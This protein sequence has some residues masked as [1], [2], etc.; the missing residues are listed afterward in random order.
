M[1]R[2]FIAPDAWNRVRDLCTRGRGPE[3]FPEILSRQTDI[4]SLP[5]YL[6]EL[7]Q[8]EWTLNHVETAENSSSPPVNQI[9]VNP[10]L[11]LLRLSWKNLTYLLKAHDNDSVPPPECGEEYVIVWRHPRTGEAAVSPATNEDLLVLKMVAEEIDAR[12]VAADGRVTIHELNA[13][14][15]RAV[16]RGLLVAPA[17]GIQR[18]TSGFPRAEEIEEDFLSASVFT[19][20]WHITQA[21][22]LHCRHCYDRSE[23][24]AVEPAQAIAILDDL[25]EFCRSRHVRGQVSF[26]GGN[27]VLYPY[28]LEVYSAASERGF[29]LAILGNPISERMI[30]KLIA[31][32]PPVFYQVSLEGLAEH[33]DLI[34]GPGHFERVLEFLTVLRHH[35]V[36][37]MVMLTLTHDNLA[38]V[39]P[40]AEVLRDRTDL[41]TFNRLSLVGEGAKLQL[42]AKSDYTAFLEAYADAAED[43]PV[44]ALKDNLINIVRHKKGLPPFGGCT[45]YGCGAA[46]NFMCVLADGSTH[47]CR[48]FP[49]PIGNMLHTSLAELYDSEAARRY[50]SGCRACRSCPVRPICG[51][52]LAIA[53]SLGLDVFEERDPYC[54]M[55]D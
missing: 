7:A 52:C 19:L 22:D 55:S 13:A 36:Y 28:F 53:Y 6:A 1:C 2:L 8:L 31:V 9:S 3:E 54:F 43:N 47:A 51:G 25:Y 37:S 38:Q 50:R 17:S 49:S 32:E 10:A 12:K 29:N 44:I 46:F 45:G 39:L 16:R 42:P 21:C 23:R 33:N 30:E 34:R 26:S 20:Q 27:P 5:G 35:N 11:H 4:P 18:D 14:I 24:Q 41:F 15:D 40:L 48:K